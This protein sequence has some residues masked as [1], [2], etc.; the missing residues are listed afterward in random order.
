MQGPEPASFLNEPS[1]HGEH[2]P[3]DM[4]VQSVRKKPGL[5]LPHAPV[6]VV[7]EIGLHE[8]VLPLE[9]VFEQFVH[10]CVPG[11]FLNV[12]EGQPV[13]YS[14]MISNTMA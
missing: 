14:R 6:H 9:H 3:F 11:A 12:P 10:A 5:Q 4:L 7:P 1:A 2:A 8:N 13:K